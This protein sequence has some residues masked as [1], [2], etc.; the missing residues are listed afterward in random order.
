[1][2]VWM[3]VRETDSDFE[4]LH[5]AVR[6]WV[7]LRAAGGLWAGLWGYLSDDWMLVDWQVQASEEGFWCH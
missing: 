2:R 5:A 7:P 6:T 4:E 1:M 3:C